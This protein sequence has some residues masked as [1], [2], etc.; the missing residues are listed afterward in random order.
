MMTSGS[1]FQSISGSDQGSAANVAATNFGQ[2]VQRIVQSNSGKHRALF[3]ASSG[4]LGKW[5][6]YKNQA[7]RFTASGNIAYAE[8]MW[9]KAIAEAQG[10]TSGDER[11]YS[12]F[13]RLAVLYFATKRFD[14]AEVFAVRAMQ[15]ARETF[16]VE[17]V[18]TVSS[19]EF[20]ANVYFKLRRYEEAVKVATEALGALEK[21][22]GRVHERTSA[23][24]FNLGVI[25]HTFGDFDKAEENYRSAYAVRFRL[26]GCDDERTVKVFRCFEELNLDRKA[27]EEAR[28]IIDKL[29]GDNENQL[30]SA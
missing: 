17:S 30:L 3:P 19:M 4:D 5:E 26:F 23:S 7:E 28:E 12:G 10:F 2:L 11:I 16:G 20:L 22:L 14:Q 25:H 8:A 24:L 18:K 21:Q 9:L 29:I 1:S 13:D 27:H 6:W 15:A